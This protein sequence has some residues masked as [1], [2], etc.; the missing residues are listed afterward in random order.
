MKKLYL[1]TALCMSAL[2]AGSVMAQSAT[3]ATSLEKA[4]T[5]LAAAGDD[6]D[7]VT[8]LSTAG[9]ALIAI[10]KSQA[11]QLT[12]AQASVNSTKSQLATANAQVASLTSANAADQQQIST[13]QSQLATET[14]TAN[15]DAGT[16][17][18]LTT[19]VNNDNAEIAQLMEE[20]AAAQSSQNSSAPMTLCQQWE[21]TYVSIPQ[22]DSLAL[23]SGSQS[24]AQVVQA[25]YQMEP[26]S[27]WYVCIQDAFGMYAPAPVP[28]T[29]A[30]A[31]QT[32][33]QLLNQTPAVLQNH[34]AYQ[35]GC[36]G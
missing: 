5:A 18:T 30:V 1:I 23:P 31:A 35:V 7:A 9:S 32:C 28:G 21:N 10:N 4:G 14:N 29:N 24:C 25:C 13:L 22:G 15:T 33:Q 11:G 6:A 3:L 17:S 19:S 26:T 16:I 27:D 20:L 36:N 8:A 34:T 12:A 2:S